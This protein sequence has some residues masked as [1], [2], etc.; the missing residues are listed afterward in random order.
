MC[1]INELGDKIRD[2]EVVIDEI[3]EYKGGKK[4]KRQKKVLPSYVFVN[5][6]YDKDLM[7]EISNIEGVLNFVSNSR[8]P[9]SIGDNEIS[10]I[11][12]RVNGAVS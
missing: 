11:I 4:R 3:I 6:I 5:M 2:V 1:E 8:G 7:Y 12:S 9:T 10:R